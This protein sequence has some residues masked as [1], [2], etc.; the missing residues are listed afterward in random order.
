M[1]CGQNSVAIA[2]GL[3]LT[4][5][6]TAMITT[7]AIMRS[8][9]KWSEP[10]SVAGRCEKSAAMVQLSAAANASSAAI[11]IG[12]KFMESW[13]ARSAEAGYQARGAC[14]L[15]MRCS[16]RRC[17]RRRRAVSDTFRPHCS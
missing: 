8:L 13:G 6:R 14:L 1:I 4:I 2:I 3:P 12:A 16:V 7:A 11:F 15:R 9:L 5:S 17:I 10:S